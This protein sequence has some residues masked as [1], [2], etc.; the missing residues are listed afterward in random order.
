[1]N[2]PIRFYNIGGEQTF[3]APFISNE[4]PKDAL[5]NVS[6]SLSQLTFEIGHPQWELMDYSVTTE[7]NIGSDSATGVDSGIY[8]VNISGLEYDKTYHWSINATDGTNEINKEFSF[9]TRKDALNFATFSDTHIGLG[10]KEN[11]PSHLDSLAQDI[12][13]NSNP[14]D[15]VV[16]LGDTINKSTAEIEGEG[17]PPCSECNHD[18]YHYYFKNFKASLLQHVNM[19]YISV[20]GNHDMTDYYHEE[21][22]SYPDNTDNPFILVKKLIDTT[23]MN[24]LLYSFMKNNILFIVLSETDYHHFT[25]PIVYEYVEY[26]TQRY[27]DNTTIIFSHQAIEDTTVHDCMCGQPELYRGKQDREYWA[28]LFTNNDQI[29]MWIHGHNHNPDWYK[30]SESSG[31]EYAVLDFGHEM[32]FSSPY[33]GWDWG[34]NESCPFQPPGFEEDRTVIYSISPNSISAKAWENNGA[35]GSWVSGYDYNWNIETSYDSNTKDWYSF[36]LFLQ[37]GE[38]QVTDMKVFSPDIT[39]ELIGTQPMELFYDPCM[40]AQGIHWSGE[41]ILPFENDSYFG[42]SGEDKPIYPIETGPGMTVEGSYDLSFPPKLP[43]RIYYYNKFGSYHSKPTSEDGRAGQPYHF[44]PLGTSHAAVPNAEYKVTIKAK[45]HTGTGT[46]NVDLSVSNWGTKSQHSTLVGSGQQVISHSFGTNYETISGTYTAPN[47]PNA[48]FLQGELEFLNNVKYDVSLF[49]IQR[50]PDPNKTTT[51]N[52][53]ISL[54]DVWYQDPCSLQRF[55]KSEFSIDPCDLADSNGRIE[56]ESSIK[57]NRYG[58]ARLIYHEP[59]LMGRNARFKVDKVDGNKYTLA[60]KKDLSFFSD[61]FKMFPLSPDYG[62]LEVNSDDGSAKIQVS[63]NYNHWIESNTPE[64]NDVILNITYEMLDGESLCMVNF[65][66]FAMLANW[67]L[68]NGCGEGNDWCDG[69]DLVVNGV[70]DVNDLVIF[71]D[72]WLY[73]CPS[74]WPW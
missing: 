26:L 6:I 44:F 16:H 18:Y 22:S 25:K 13:D 73:P 58:M 35:E 56:I 7:P 15:F 31:E 8:T 65:D 5:Q 12:M 66:H 42:K 62:K 19:P 49:S 36:P 34:N 3:D 39:L 70:V 9:T 53:G 52:F 50:Q 1:M 67:W 29:K 68:V 61:T 33:S 47:E 59:V 74:G 55:Q 14:C 71:N 10:Y 41:N 57:G 27:P 32:V 11:G 40:Q 64:V 4:T 37:D 17:L 72:N 28:D 60:L 24:S 21:D 38:I 2:R 23:E 54:N 63:D 51:D 48:W 30:N 20:L 46:I 69:A 45:T 43:S